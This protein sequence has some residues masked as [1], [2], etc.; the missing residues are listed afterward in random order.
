MRGLFTNKLHTVQPGQAISGIAM[1]PHMLRIQRGRVWL[2]VEGISHDY[3]LSAGDTFTAIPGRL[4][5]MEADREAQVD[6]RQPSALQALHGIRG[7][8]SAIVG[9]MTRAGTVQ[10]SRPCSKAC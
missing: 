10:T 4:V 9:R 2:T 7:M 1:R 6:S 5:V 3:F 8:F